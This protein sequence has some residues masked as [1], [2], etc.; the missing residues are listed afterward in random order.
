MIRLEREQEVELTFASFK[1]KIR[2]LENRLRLH[3]KFG[4]VGG[5]AGSHKE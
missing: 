5:N 1:K 4:E 2:Q 3:S